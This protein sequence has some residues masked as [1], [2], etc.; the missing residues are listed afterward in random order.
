MRNL[1]EDLAKAEKKQEDRSEEK[2]NPRKGEDRNDH[3]PHHL[4]PRYHGSR[5]NVATT[6]A[7]VIVIMHHDHPWLLFR[8]RTMLTTNIPKG[9]QQ[10]RNR[11]RRILTQESLTLNFITR[12]QW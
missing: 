2:D 1:R 10:N 12:I 4:L 9:K 11:L 3:H 7:P 6:E 5:A 8:Q